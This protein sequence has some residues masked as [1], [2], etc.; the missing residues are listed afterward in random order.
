MAELAAQAGPGMQPRNQDQQNGQEAQQGGKS[1]A[2]FSMTG[3][4]T[5][6]GWLSTKAMLLATTPADDDAVERI[7]AE[8]E[9]RGELAIARAFRDQASSILP[10]AR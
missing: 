4:T 8:L 9:R 2:P 6:D 7:I 10:R 1:A 3:L 5:R